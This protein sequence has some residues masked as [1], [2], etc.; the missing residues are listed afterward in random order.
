M[1]VSCFGCWTRAIPQKSW[2][3]FSLKTPLRVGEVTRCIVLRAQEGG[4]VSGEGTS[5]SP[6]LHFVDLASERT[7]WSGALFACGY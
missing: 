6:G 5:C 3:N 4:C 7:S 1:A 2:S